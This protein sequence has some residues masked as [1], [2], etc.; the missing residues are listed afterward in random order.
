M[1]LKDTNHKLSNKHAFLLS[2][3]HLH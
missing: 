3:C 2:G 1:W